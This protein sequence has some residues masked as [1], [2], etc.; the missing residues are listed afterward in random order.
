LVTLQERQKW[1][2]KTRNLAVDDVVLVADGSP[3]GQWQMA[4]VTEVLP[5]REGRVRSNE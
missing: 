3:R 1:T 2:Q 5:D 4:K